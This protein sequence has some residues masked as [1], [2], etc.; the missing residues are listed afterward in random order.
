MN[1]T[2]FL[3]V[4]NVVTCTFLYH[5][6]TPL[7][8]HIANFLKN[9]EPSVTTLLPF[10]SLLSYTCM[11]IKLHVLV[12]KGHYSNLWCF[13]AYQFHILPYDLHVLH[14]RLAPRHMYMID[15]NTSSVNHCCPYKAWHSRSEGVAWTP[16]VPYQ[17]PYIIVLCSMILCVHVQI[18][19]YIWWWN[20]PSCSS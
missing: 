11:L 18:T 13:S 3:S 9:Y 10:C 16:I 6:E 2:W 4:H 8:P 12:I 1:S 20:K 17:T 5:L 7:C 19:M 15:V 14:N